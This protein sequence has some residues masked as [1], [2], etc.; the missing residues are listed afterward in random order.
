ML[1]VIHEKHGDRRLD[2]YFGFREKT[3][4]AV[5]A[6]LEAENART[7]RAL[8]P[9]A[10]LQDQLY[11]EILG[12]IQE[13]DV[14]V[15][16]RRGPW[17]YYTRTEAGLSYG[18]H[19]RRQATTE[20]ILIDGNALAA[21][22]EYFRLGVLEPSPNQN[23]LAYS[24]DYTG[25]EKY[26]LVFQNLETGLMLP[27][28]I[29]HTH[30]DVV[31]ASDNQ[32]VFYTK[33]DEVTL[34]PY[35]VWR[36]HLGQPT[37]SLVYE[38]PDE[39]FLVG[40][41]KTRDQLYIVLSVHSSTSSEIYTIPAHDPLAAPTVIAPR[42]PQVEYSIGHQHGYFL[43]HTNFE[44]TNFRL[45]R[46]P[47]ATPSA[48]ENLVPH[49]PEVYL[50]SFAEFDQHLVLY[51]RTNGLRQINIDQTHYIPVPEP[52]YHLTSQPNPNFDTPLFRYAYTSLTTPVTVYDY[53][54]ETRQS[55]ELKREP[56]LGGYDPTQ[57]TTERLWATATD[58]T[59]IPIAIVYKTGLFRPD[60]NSPLLLYGYGSYGI[61]IEATFKSD[62]L[63]LLD[64][65]FAYAIATIR[66]GSELGRPWY[67]HGKFL[68]KR[69]TFTDFIAAAEH[70]I[71]QNY[72]Q[73]RH[74]AIEGRS[75][76]GLLIGAVLNM[77]PDL[78]GAALAGVPFVDVLTTMLDET[79]PLTVGEY[80]EWGDPND[81]TYYHYMKS[82]SPYDN[83]T[84]QPYP[85]LLI[86]SGLNDPRV[87]Y[88]EPTKWAARLRELRTN[89]NL[90]LLKTNMGAGH[91]GKSGRYDALKETA[92][93]FAFF[94]LALG[95]TETDPLTVAD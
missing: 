53:N 52:V 54:M 39:R 90:L 30:S 80:E 95:Q 34:R 44:A 21:G 27:D 19:C 15:P 25:D 12:R 9:T 4:P 68:E 75:A 91:F 71:A 77:R 22:H 62:R 74:L 86:T 41:D 93:Y 67:D 64:R 60:G 56:V 88:W 61:N 43:I 85:H 63:S 36:H 31:W 83:V 10:H 73:P 33:L 49:R 26:T 6:H 70:L 92:L 17:E 14:S 59:Q 40:I 55:T 66:G 47:V 24:T 69:N 11:T 32:T 58:G 7:D 46:A 1:P 94:L 35:Q 5:L 87:Q 65:G 51:E 37:D 29:P 13:T 78:F 28:E 84:A 50:E 79:L 45:M 38:E 16:V 42:R 89:R 76:G 72:V 18:I 48:W 57:Y 2:P 3:N 81:P 82:Y 20:Q 8:A 23:L